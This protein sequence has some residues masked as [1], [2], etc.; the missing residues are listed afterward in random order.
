MF[1][2]Q[3]TK[4]FQDWLDGLRDVRAQVAVAHRLDRVRAGNLGDAKPV[5][6]GVSELRV[7]VGRATGST[8]SSAAE[9]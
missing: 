9:S 8:L 2:V 6:N 7:D 4:S 3:L 5:G 1:M